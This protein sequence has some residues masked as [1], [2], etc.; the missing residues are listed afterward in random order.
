MGWTACIYEKNK[1][2]GNYELVVRSEPLKTRL[3]RIYNFGLLFGYSNDQNGSEVVSFLNDEKSS[4][5]EIEGVPV[6]PER[7]F[8]SFCETYHIYVYDSYFVVYRT[9]ESGQLS[10]YRSVQE[11]VSLRIS[12]SWRGCFGRSCSSSPPR[13]AST[14]CR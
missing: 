4:N 8:V 12:R 14:S 7:V 5:K 3:F 6:W 1:R 11:T 9:E 13:A 10:Y 2:S